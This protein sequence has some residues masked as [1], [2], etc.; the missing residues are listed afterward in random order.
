MRRPFLHFLAVWISASV[1]TGAASVALAGAIESGPFIPVGYSPDEDAI[2]EQ[3]DLVATGLGWR[4]RFDGYDAIDRLFERAHIDFSAAVEPL[5]MVL[6]VED[7]EAFEA[8]VVP[9]FQLRVAGWDRISP[10]FEGGIG[11]VYTTL[12]GYG[13]GSPVN[14]SDNAGI[15]I[16]FGPES[17]VQWTIGYRFRHISNLG[18]WS[19][20]NDGLNA[21]FLVVAV[22]L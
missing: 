4:W 14:F 16:A 9:Y 21:H 6:I 19:D 10:Y 8:S 5:A 12:S 20:H 2:E 7:Q 1:A 13:L 11:L 3:M 18:L 22:D 17:S 15:G